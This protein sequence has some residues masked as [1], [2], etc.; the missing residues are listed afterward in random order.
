MSG[1]LLLRPGFRWLWLGQTLLFAGVQFW[2]VAVTW[3]MLQRT[4]SGTSLA[5]VLMAAA[6]PRGLLL[7]LGGVLSDRHPPRT[8]AVRA[9]T[10]LATA[11]GVLTL[12]ASRDALDLGPVLV[13]AAVFGAAEACLYPAALALLPRLLEDR[14]LGRA[15]AWLQGSEQISNVAGPA[16]AGLSLAVAGRRRPWPSTPLCCCSPWAASCRCGLAW[17]RRTRPRRGAWGRACGRGSPSPGA[18]GRSARA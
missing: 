11:T 17:P 9:G 15:H 14:H 16:L 12:L 13:L 2:F 3:L 8:M 6:L 18:T 4:G 7:L 5:L 10:I 1:S